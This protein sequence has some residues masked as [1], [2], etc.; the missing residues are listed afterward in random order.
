[1]DKFFL[2]QKIIKDRP[3]AY[4]PDFAKAIGSVQAALF[5]SQLLYWSD[6]G[7]N[8][9]WIYKTQKE[10]YEET[11]LSR[12]EQETARKKLKKLG[13]LEEKYQG[14]PRKLYY[15]INMG[16]LGEFML[17]YYSS[18]NNNVE[19][20][21]Y[22][23]GNSSKQD[24]VN[25][26]RK[27]EEIPHANTEI[28]TE[29]TTERENIYSPH[30]EK[31]VPLKKEEEKKKE[32]SC[33]CES[34]DDVKKKANKVHS[35]YVSPHAKRIIEV[36]K[37]HY[38]NKFGCPP[39]IYPKAIERLEEQLKFLNDGAEKAAFVDK[40]IEVIPD[41]LNSNDY[42]VKHKVNYSFS[43]FVSQLPKLLS[44][45]SSKKLTQSEKKAKKIDIG[46]EGVECYEGLW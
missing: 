35:K 27:L 42:F 39:A 3:V 45:G 41:Y 14:V 15:R 38:M 21:H 24:C 46:I 32:E 10:F 2:F 18:A 40:A 1:M 22:R 20:Q 34:F 31:N 8:D 9:G 13:I 6:K 17:A 7:N 19:I 26:A 16:K 37:H 25:P 5:L 44:L 43:G 4:H 36:F 23:V 29:T 28:T 12:Y 30:S 11:G 33:G